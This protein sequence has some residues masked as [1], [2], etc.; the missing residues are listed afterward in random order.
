MKLNIITLWRNLVM[1][2]RNPVTEMEKKFF[3]D[4]ISDT[5]K[6]KDSKII[7]KKIREDLNMKV[8][9]KEIDSFFQ[10]DFELE[11]RKVEFSLRLN[12]IF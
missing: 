6:T 5:Y 9:V 1:R 3:S 12:D 8:S 2:I 11:N 10:E 7:S 4:L